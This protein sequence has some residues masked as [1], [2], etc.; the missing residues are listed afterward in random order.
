MLTEYSK[1]SADVAAHTARLIA[2]NA[3]LLARQRRIMAVLRDAPPRRHCILCDAAL[4]GSK[5]FAHREIA[6]RVCD[7]CGHVQC[8]TKAPTGYP[9]H[10]QNFTDIYRPLDAHAYAQ[11][12]ERIYLPKLD[13]VLRAAKAIGLGDV[14]ERSWVELGSGAGNFLA[15]LRAA[16]ASQVMGL[17]AEAALVEQASTMLEQPLVRHFSGSLVDAVRAHPADV[18]VAWF[19]LEHCFE[20]AEVLKVLSERPSGTL[21]M[22][23][24][25]TLGLSALLESAFDSHYARSLDSVLHLQLFTECSIR[26]AM[27]RADYEIRAEWIF[28]QDADDLYRAIVTQVAGGTSG[29]A[30]GRKLNRLGAALNGIQQAI[31][32]AR[33]SDA[34]HILAVRR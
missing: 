19:V 23:A 31:D 6:Y 29:E 18:Y 13:W 14:L 33:L 25:P 9:Y 24:V 22:F 10:E 11:R 16:G 2:N 21:L 4:N 32:R 5:G 20:L 8:A 27:D 26:H 17:E 7:S 15:A 12:T 30:L 3:D 1:P 34:R 28:G